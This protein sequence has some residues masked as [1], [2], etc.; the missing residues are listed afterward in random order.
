MPL[1]LDVVQS[2]DLVGRGIIMQG[3]VNT[4]PS[5]I[6]NQ[7]KSLPFLTKRTRDH[8]CVFKKRVAYFPKVQNRCKSNLPNRGRVFPFFLQTSKLAAVLDR[9]HLSYW[10][11]FSP[12]R[13]FG[14]DWRRGNHEREGNPFIRKGRL[15]LADR[16]SGVR[17]CES[18]G[19]LKDWQMHERI[20]QLTNIRLI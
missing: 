4:R 19:I 18:A 20:Q 2:N 6:P 17:K 13:L 8:E 7:C 11:S 16:L 9:H 1:P 12:E 14:K 5:V 15:H 10:P 3:N